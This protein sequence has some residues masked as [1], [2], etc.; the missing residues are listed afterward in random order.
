MAPCKGRRSTG[1]TRLDRRRARGDVNVPFIAAPTRCLT[2][3]SRCRSDT[4]WAGPF[5]PATYSLAVVVAPPGES[6][7]SSIAS[8][9]LNLLLTTRQWSL[10]CT[11]SF[12]LLSITWFG[13]VCL[14]GCLKLNKVPFLQRSH[15][16][17]LKAVICM[18]IFASSPTARAGGAFFSS[19]P[20]PLSPPRSARPTPSSPLVVCVLCASVSSEFQEKH[21][22]FVFVTTG[23]TTETCGFWSWT[24]S[25][26]FI[27]TEHLY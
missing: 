19:H 18:T 21:P 6:T 5:M 20:L 10:L 16:S 15:A 13:L 7:R 22:A 14:T 17:F 24:A 25:Y 3:R 12:I 1:G 2:G 8:C 27:H 9:F 4:R 11:M 26:T 23:S